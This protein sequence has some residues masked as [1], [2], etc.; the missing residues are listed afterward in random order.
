M[1][2]RVKE[3]TRSLTCKNHARLLVRAAGQQLVVVTNSGR[4]GE[5]ADSVMTS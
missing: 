1:V 2:N 3:K 4:G 5:P